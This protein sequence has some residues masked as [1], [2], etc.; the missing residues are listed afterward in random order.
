[1]QRCRRY[2]N[3]S[4]AIVSGVCRDF[5]LSSFPGDER[6]RQRGEERRSVSG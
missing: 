4:R 6:C 2:R 3:A 5:C 1:V